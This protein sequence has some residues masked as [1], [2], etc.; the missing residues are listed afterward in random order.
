MAGAPSPTPGISLDGRIVVVTGA[1][2]G[3]GLA[4]A[5]ALAGAGARLVLADLDEPSARRACEEAEGAGTRAVPAGGDIATEAGCAAIAQIAGEAFGCVD[6]L[7]NNA[8]LLSALP[9]RPWE[10][11]PVAEW[12]AVMSVNVRGT[13]LCTRAIAPLMRPHGGAIVNMS[14]GRALDPGVHRL[15]YATSKAG[16]LGL[17]RG[18]ARE[19]G[20]DRIRVNA[21]TPGYV[22]PDEPPAPGEAGPSFPADGRALER[23]MLSGDLTGVITFL[24]SD[25]AAFLTGQTINVDGGKILY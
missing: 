15:H 13:F 2:H 7:V 17:T 18:L 3:L 21:V 19:L 24:L 5:R 9:L 16:V 4:I 6:G 23:A 25:A 1:G 10:E 22:Q 8:G 20:P 14:S 12:D 11:I